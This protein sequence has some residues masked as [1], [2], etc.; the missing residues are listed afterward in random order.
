M[1]DVRRTC[2]MYTFGT[3]SSAVFRKGCNPATL[4]LDFGVLCSIVVQE[5]QLIFKPIEK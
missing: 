2:T 3:V 4:L 1:H 5:A